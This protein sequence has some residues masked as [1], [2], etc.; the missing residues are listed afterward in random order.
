MP[1]SKQGWELHI[2]RQTVQKRASDG[3][4]RTV[5]V[6]QVYHDGQPVAGLSGQ[7]AESRGP[8]DN[9]VAEN[10]KRVEPG[11]YP[12]WT[13]DGTKY[14][15]I[16]YVDNLSTSA[17]PKPGIELKNTGARA[18]ILIHPGVN[19][20]LSS[21]GCINLCTSLPNAAEPISYVGSRRRVIALIDDMKAFL[22]NDFPSQNSRRIPRAQVVI[23]GEP[24]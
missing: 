17:R 9:S 18:E 12:L 23:E 15:T 11:V 20:F 5:G 16:G 6:Y 3:K 8:G 24:A 1:I 14:D 10:G 22:K 7:T 13:Q 19:G 2:V 4:K 21:I